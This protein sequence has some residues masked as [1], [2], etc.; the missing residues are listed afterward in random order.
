LNAACCCVDEVAYRPAVVKATM[1]L[2]RW[3]RCELAKLSMHLDNRWQTGYWTENLLQPEGCCDVCQRRSAWLL[4]GGDGDD[5]E[6]Q[7]DPRP[8]DDFVAWHA[9][10]VCGWCKPSLT[11]VTNQAEWESALAAARQRSISWRWRWRPV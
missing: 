7:D 4:V 5:E 10:H 11:G 6:F 1:P 8:T 3:W 2:P 9:V